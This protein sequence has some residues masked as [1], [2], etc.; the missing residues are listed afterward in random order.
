MGGT[1]KTF[2]NDGKYTLPVDSITVEEVGANGAIAVK[3]HFADDKNGVSFPD[4]TEWLSFKETTSKGKPMASFRQW[5]YKG[6]F[7]VLGL[8]EEDAK[9]TVEACEKSDKDSS[10]AAYRSAFEKIGH[11]HPKVA[12]E[13]YTEAGSNGRD[14]ACG[15]FADPSIA[16]PRTPKPATQNL[17][18]ATASEETIDTSELPF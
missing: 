17:G 1:H 13:V 6:I 15:A 16:M 5:R 14:Y 4:I 9:K 18:E 12:V 2:A 10:V 7:Q 11:K 3:V 8:S